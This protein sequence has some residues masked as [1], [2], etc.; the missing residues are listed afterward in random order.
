M[1]PKL[2]NFAQLLRYYALIITLSLSG[3]KHSQR[4]LSVQASPGT[5]ETIDRS[6]CVLSLFRNKPVDKGHGILIFGMRMLFRTH[7]HN[8]VLIK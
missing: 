3:R 8:S 2:S 5:I 4:L 6:D 7:S 1:N